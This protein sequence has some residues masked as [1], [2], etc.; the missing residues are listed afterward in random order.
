[1]QRLLAGI[2]KFRRDNYPR[3]KTLFARL[4][5]N[6][7]PRALFITCSD[8]RVVPDLIT[9]SEPGD[10]F[11]CRNAGNMVPPYGGVS[12]GVSAT[13]EYAVAALKV[14]HVVICGHSQCGAMKG[15]LHPEA[16]KDMPAV[17]SWLE[18]AA[19]ARAVVA[20]SAEGLNEDQLLDYMV[21]E[22][23]IDIGPAVSQ[24]IVEAL[25]G[26]LEVRQ[27]RHDVAFV[28]RLPA[29]S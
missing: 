16:V 11:I 5:H 2:R 4:A 1:M 6:Q 27:G 23:V 20:Q 28:L 19:A 13:I 8:S 29:A 7:H 10:L 21:Q 22:N 14:R 9:Q 25:G 18:N 3:K 12:G 24:R 17:A 15:V 26:R